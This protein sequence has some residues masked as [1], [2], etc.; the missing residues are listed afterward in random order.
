MLTYEIIVKNDS[1]QAVDGLI[2]EEYVPTAMRIADVTPKATFEDQRLQ[3]MLSAIGPRE[4]RK[5]EV[6]LI[7]LKDGAAE[8][9]TIAHPVAA[10]ATET[11][12]DSSRL[13]LEVTTA[14]QVAS[15]KICPL[16]FHITNVGKTAVEGVVLHADL[17]DGLVH[18]KGSSL[19]LTIDKIE[20]SETHTTQLNPRANILGAIVMPASLRIGDN[21]VAEAS[22][23]VRIVKSTAKS[24]KS[25]RRSTTLPPCNCVPCCP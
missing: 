8:S 10:V 7:P 19:D 3:W 18:A 15:G 22:A 20:P 1:S 12:V 6:N 14:P 4:E 16:V 21:Q 24:A 23:N 5:L 13:R 11:Q 2:I 25:T 9:V 17:P